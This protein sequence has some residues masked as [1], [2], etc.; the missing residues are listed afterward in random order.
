MLL[1]NIIKCYGTF[2]PKKCLLYYVFDKMSKSS[3]IQQNTTKY[4]KIQQNTTNKVICV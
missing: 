3:K 2:E 4:N 1:I